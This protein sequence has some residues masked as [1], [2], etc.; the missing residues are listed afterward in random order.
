[1]VFKFSPKILSQVFREMIHLKAFI[2]AVASGQ[3]AIKTI[4]TN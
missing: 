4:Y 2:S 1:M 3:L